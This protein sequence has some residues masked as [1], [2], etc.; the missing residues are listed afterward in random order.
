MN[1][2]KYILENT[3]QWEEFVYVAY[4]RRP[5]ALNTNAYKFDIPVFQNQVL[6]NTV[7]MKYIVDLES[8]GRPYDWKFIL[9]LIPEKISVKSN[10][11]Q[12]SFYKTLRK[13]KKGFTKGHS[14]ILK[15]KHPSSNNVDLVLQDFDKIIHLLG[16]ELTKTYSIAIFTNYSV[17]KNIVVKDSALIW[18]PDLNDSIFY[19]EVPLK[20]IKLLSKKY[21]YIPPEVRNVRYF[22]NKR[23]GFKSLCQP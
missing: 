5:P 8:E 11:L 13:D 22:E 15:N 19:H 1:I 14:I 16:N 23:N 4:E 7:S 3:E 17:I 12:G 21:P 18:Y 2:E 9:P 10:I 6:A 20:S